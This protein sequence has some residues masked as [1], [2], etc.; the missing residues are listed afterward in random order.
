MVK[1]LL[2]GLLSGCGQSRTIEIDHG[3]I[4]KRYKQEEEDC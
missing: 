2:K 4:D 1:C 3:D